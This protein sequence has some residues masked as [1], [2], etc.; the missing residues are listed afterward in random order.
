MTNTGLS[1]E[2]RRV[3]TD[4]LALSERD[5]TAIIGELFASLESLTAGLDDDTRKEIERRIAALD[6]RDEETYSAEEVFEELEREH[7]WK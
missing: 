2:G 1:T 3:L 5:R 7:G 4:A 6:D